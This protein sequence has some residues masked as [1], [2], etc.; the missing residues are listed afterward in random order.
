MEHRHLLQTS[1]IAL[2]KALR[3]KL[4]TDTILECLARVT[5]LGSYRLVHN[6]FR[7]PR[8]STRRLVDPTPN[9]NELPPP[10]D[11]ADALAL[12][13]AALSG[14]PKLVTA[15][16]DGN[17]PPC[18]TDLPAVRDKLKSLYAGRGPP[19]R[20][21]PPLP[22]CTNAP[23]PTAEELQAVADILRAT[24][25]TTTTGNDNICLA[26]LKNAFLSKHDPGLH[27]LHPLATLF[28][29]F[30]KGALA[31][32]SLSKQFRDQR[33]VAISKDQV[34]TPRPIGILSLISRLSGRYITKVHKS[35]LADAL[36][37]HDLGAVKGGAHRLVLYANALLRSDDKICVVLRDATNAFT[38]CHKDAINAALLDLP[39]ATLAL[40]SGYIATVYGTSS[41]VT[42]ND[43]RI[44]VVDGV[45]QG[46]P[47]ASWMFAL[48]HGHALRPVREAALLDGC[49]L[50]AF[51]DDLQTI[52]PGHLV[53]KHFLAADKALA[54]IGCHRSAAKTVI[55][56]GDALPPDSTGPHD[57]VGSRLATRLSSLCPEQPL[58]CRRGAT[59]LGSSLSAHKDYHVSALQAETDKTIS[60]IAMVVLAAAQPHTPDLPT[61]QALLYVLTK[62]ILPGFL[63]FISLQPPSIT[64]N[65]ARQV[66]DKV[67]EAVRALLEQAEATDA[68]ADE[69]AIF[70][71]ELFLPSREGGLGATDMEVVA[72]AAWMG[73]CA[74]YLSH[75]H[76][77]LHIGTGVTIE[78]AAPE[79]TQTIALLRQLLPDNAAL[80]N[81]TAAS[82]LARPHLQLQQTIT[83][84]IQA[85]TATDH[86]ALL[87]HDLTAHARYMSRATPHVM[88]WL[89]LSTARADHRMTDEQMMFA[90]YANFNIQLPRRFQSLPTTGTCPLC[91]H[92]FTDLRAHHGGCSWLATTRTHRH[93]QVIEA[94]TTHFLSL[95]A[96]RM[97]G[98]H[99]ALTNLDVEG[100]LPTRPG[101]PHL[102]PAAVIPVIA[103][104]AL[105]NFVNPTMPVNLLLDVGVSSLEPLIAAGSAAAKKALRLGTPI[106]PTAGIDDITSDK[107]SKYGH[108][109]VLD[110]AFPLPSFHPLA[111]NSDGAWSPTT[112]KLIADITSLALPLL[113]AQTGPPIDF[114]GRR[115]RAL[116]DLH[117]GVALAIQQGNADG[118]SKLWR[119]H[120]AHIHNAGA[121]F[122]ADGR[123]LMGTRTA[124]TQDIAALTAKSHAAIAADPNTTAH[125]AA[126]KAAQDKSRARNLRQR[127]NTRARGLP[128]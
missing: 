126:A 100:K 85:R 93:T 16:L 65:P 69:I 50:P 24:S 17:K 64:R 128:S 41:T 19:P 63:Y 4:P 42:F 51:A 95:E 36:H 104:I 8:P 98:F 6:K 48:T 110:A 68:N 123:V 22:G 26:A 74:A 122:A 45:I 56:G 82:L 80:R 101:L 29:Y 107:L 32:P 60:K 53:D 33:G 47:L 70:R 13:T 38:A 121:T 40:V 86:A 73:T 34:G 21:L 84:G 99:T 76:Q 71:R 102:R 39:P 1:T 106:P 116:N 9:H 114:C 90:F 57:T 52:G 112:L 96:V 88:A 44:D 3:D 54:N 105:T 35:V 10:K 108:R 87:R 15:V 5:L 125:I 2:N 30:N 28:Y 31:H 18:D 75:L 72:P 12:C 27:E 94:L 119:I 103:D 61:L 46:C 127:Q 113:V 89:H 92:A 20:P 49:V 120:S 111:F 115:S 67:L 37:P 77:E 109:Y 83:H 58:Q 66:N 59:L 118:W 11:I 23:P 7:K 55:T 25:S 117:T 62:Q 91:S 43:L 124:S 79:I 81:C 14:K 78:H 97:V